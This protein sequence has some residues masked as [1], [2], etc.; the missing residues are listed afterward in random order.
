MEE[1]LL[2]KPLIERY[3]TIVE[4]FNYP[5]KGIF[6]PANNPCGKILFVGYNPSLG[7]D[8]NSNC[9]IPFKDLPDN[10]DFWAPV[11]Q[12][13]KNVINDVAYIDLFPIHSSSQP[14]LEEPKY[15]DLRTELLEI[16]QHEIETIIK[17]KLIVFLNRSADYYWGLNDKALWMGYDFQNSEFENLRGNH[18][19]KI[20]GYKAS[21]ERNI[22]I[23]IER[24]S[25]DS[26]QLV[27]NKTHVLFYRQLKAPRGKQY[28]IESVITPNELEELWNKIK[29]LP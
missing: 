9:D 28:S 3:Q 23:N 25:E 2:Q 5:Y 1:Y 16:T 8:P 7:K 27:A 21:S 13:A 22:R 19:Y 26:S 18:I 17:P 24:F 15:N 6:C 14:Y 4:K 12:F 10:D 11:K 29:Q 20:C